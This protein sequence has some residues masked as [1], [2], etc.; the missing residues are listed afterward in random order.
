MTYWYRG[1]R[2]V[3]AE[4]GEGRGEKVN[5]LFKEKKGATY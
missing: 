5:L 2:G 4:E 3:G 1:W